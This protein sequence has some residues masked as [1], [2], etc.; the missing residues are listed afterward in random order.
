MS[1]ITSPTA[2]QEL[3]EL[4]RSEGSMTVAEMAQNM[5][6]TP[7]AI[8]QRIGRLLAHG[9]VR[10]EAIRAGR[11]RPSHRYYLT[12]KGLRRMGSNFT[13]LALALWRQIGQI[14]NPHLR[15]QLIRQ[16]ARSLAA[17]YADQV[18]GITTG[19]RM[20][21]ISRLLEQR[22]V[23]FSVDRSNGLPVLTAQGCPYQELAEEDRT[24]C[25]L[26][27]MLFSELLGEEVRL[28]QCRL[29]GGHGCRF[30]PV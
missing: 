23:P 16:V 20:Q 21:A 2:D 7:T 30:R 26:E 5:G 4:L 15:H 8:R 10:R 6:V 19:E 17:Q 3:L 11:G 28:A 25:H 24:I 1:I 29:D 14:E 9:L 22:Q 27:E 12:S 18:R 13:D